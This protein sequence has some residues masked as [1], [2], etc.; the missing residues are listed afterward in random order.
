MTPMCVDAA[1]PAAGVDGVDGDA[2]SGQRAV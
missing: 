2:M 1:G